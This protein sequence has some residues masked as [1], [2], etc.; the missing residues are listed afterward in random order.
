MAIDCEVDIVVT[1]GMRQ[2]WANCYECQA[3][4]SCRPALI[5]VVAKRVGHCLIPAPRHQVPG[6][7]RRQVLANLFRCT[8][9]PKSDRRYIIVI[10]HC[11]TACFAMSYLL[12]QECRLPYI[13][14]E[15]C[16]FLETE[17]P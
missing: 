12:L 6:V 3:A 16:R 5:H 2:E 14:V 15:L 11:C 1:L 7:S 10:E 9:E 4:E 8:Q 13:T 17:Q